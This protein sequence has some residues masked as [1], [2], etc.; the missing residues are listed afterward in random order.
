M[1]YEK[2]FKVRKSFDHCPNL[3]PLPKNPESPART[4]FY[5][6]LI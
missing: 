2:V 1:P 5:L 4:A 6:T 3:V